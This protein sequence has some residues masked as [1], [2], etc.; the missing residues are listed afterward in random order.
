MYEK[1][2]ARAIAK[3]DRIISR[4]GDLDGFRN[5]DKYLEMLIDEAFV[6]ERACIVSAVINH[7]RQEEGLLKR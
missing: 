4:E 3:R 1:I 2:V 5:T 7:A 6:E